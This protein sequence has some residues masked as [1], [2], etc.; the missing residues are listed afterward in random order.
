MIRSIVDFEGV[1]EHRDVAVHVETEDGHVALNLE[2]VWARPRSRIPCA[3]APCGSYETAE[4]ELNP[5]RAVGGLDM[6][7]LKT[8]KKLGRL[9]PMWGWAAASSTH[10]WPMPSIL[11]GR[12]H[13]RS[14]WED[15]FQVGKVPPD[16][17]L[18]GMF[19]TLAVNASFS[20]PEVSRLLDLKE[21]TAEEMEPEPL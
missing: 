17:R 8:G 13:E 1:A 2:G 9:M 7:G 20:N 4:Y 18:E 11:G 3:A 6:D 12:G 15:P 10:S 5:H 19:G 16:P 21:G 14:E